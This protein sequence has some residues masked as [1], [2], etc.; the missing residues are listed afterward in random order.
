MKGVILAGGNGSRLAPQTEFQSKA[1]VMVYDRPAIEYPLNTLRRMGCESAVVVASPKSVGE[2]ASYFKDG[3]RVDLDLEYTIQNTPTGVADALLRTKNAVSG[4]FPVLLGDV[5]F[6]SPLE[7]QD[8]ATLFWHEFEFANQH[9][10]WNPEQDIIV[11][12][13]RY[14]DLGHK[15][16][17]G[18]YYDERVFEFI[19][20]MSPAES[21]ELELV[22][23]HNFYRK[24]G[25]NM[26]EYTGFFADMGTPDGVL[27]AANHIRDGK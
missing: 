13:P 9:S 20:S 1:M 14:I 4:S 21:G 15:A 6:D 3:E 7:P 5:Y 16:I 12:K 19:E 26:V 27:R 24:L 11:E 18:Y 8:K 10:V 23:V 17:V 25:A 2:I 22:D